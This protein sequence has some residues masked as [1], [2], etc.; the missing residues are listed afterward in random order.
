MPKNGHFGVL[1][2]LT[3]TPLVPAGQQA[4]LSAMLL[5]VTSRR[6]L[7]LVPLLLQPATSANCAQKVTCADLAWSVGLQLKAAADGCLRCRG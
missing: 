1:P 4:I 6:Y 7:P 5:T 3:P 2:P